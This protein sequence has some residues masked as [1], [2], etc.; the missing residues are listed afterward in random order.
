M[1]LLVLQLVACTAPYATNSTQQ[2][3]Q[4]KNGP[5][6]VVPP[7]L[8]KDNLS[9]FYNLPSQNKNAQVSI[10]PPTD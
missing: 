9:D 2:Y 7:S 8:T 6:L 4:S 3:M 10:V 5:N 1:S